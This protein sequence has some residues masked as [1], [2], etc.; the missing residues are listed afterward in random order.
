MTKRWHIT[1]DAATAYDLMIKAVAQIAQRWSLA[2]LRKR[3]YY[4]LAGWTGVI[5]EE[6]VR[7]TAKLPAISTR[8]ATNCSRG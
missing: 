2:R 3:R 1:P 6:L 7:L 8:A 5:R 4:S